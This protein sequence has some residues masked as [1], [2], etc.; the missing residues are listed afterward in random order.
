[1]GFT[2]WRSNAL[3]NFDALGLSSGVLYSFKDPPNPWLVSNLFVGF[4]K[5]I[6]ENFELNVYIKD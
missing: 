1:M 2:G 5:L 4:P 6:F 3:S